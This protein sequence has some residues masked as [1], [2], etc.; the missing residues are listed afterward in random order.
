MC[1]EFVVGGVYN[2]KR[3]KK[4]KKDERCCMNFFGQDIARYRRKSKEDQLGDRQGEGCRLLVH[5]F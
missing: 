5:L 2:K 1:P 4:K 3:V